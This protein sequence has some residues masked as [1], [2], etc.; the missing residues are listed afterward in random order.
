MILQKDYVLHL[1]SFWAVDQN[2]SQIRLKDFL[3]NR[4]FESYKKSEKIQM[5]LDK[6]TNQFWLKKSCFTSF[7]VE[8]FL[9]YF[10]KDILTYSARGRRE[11]GSA[12]R[13][14]Y[15]AREKLESSE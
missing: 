5:W 13:V 14:C 12:E 11:K 9:N 7:I 6:L 15:Y 2:D 10:V 3:I 8:H 1:K 4:V